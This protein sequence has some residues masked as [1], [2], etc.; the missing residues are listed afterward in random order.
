MRAFADLLA[1]IGQAV[2]FAEYWERQ[3]LHIARGDAAFYRNLLTKTAIDAL[4]ASGGL[5]FPAIQLAQGGGFY[6]PEAFTRSLRAGEDNFTGIPDL[7]RIRAEYQA[8]ATIALPGLQ[9]AWA[10]LGDL[11]SAI[12]AELSHAVHANG[13]VSP[14]GA[15]GFLP[16]YDTHEVFALQIAGR[17][18]WRIEPPPDPLPHRSRPFAPA[19]YR[20][21]PPCLEVELA[22]GDL[23]YLP[24]GF[25]HST[26]TSDSFSVHVTLGI[27]VYSWADLVAEWLHAAEGPAILRQ[28]LPPGFARD[29]ALAGHLAARLAQALAEWPSPTQLAPAVERV[30][31]RVRSAPAPV[32]A[33]FDADVCVIGPDT[34]LQAPDPARYAIAREAAQVV[35]TFAQRR[36]RFTGETW[37]LFAAMAGL[38]RFSVSTLPPHIDAAAALTLART[39]V[40][41]E[42]LARVS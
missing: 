31:A 42:F 26:H 32:P 41:L 27:A 10:P 9:R 29:P 37:P 20:P 14:G 1:P 36:Y 30:C 24:R 33:R 39:L 34:V 40:D 12:E 6:P 8:G 2:F 19:T 16:H 21:A 15:P 18:H 17:K 5:R 22:A 28:A 4:I 13:Y 23:L 25:L 7:V 3:P 38:S 11:T 35:L